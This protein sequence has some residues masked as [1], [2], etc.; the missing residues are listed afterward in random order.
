MPNAVK[1]CPAVR[2]ALAKEISQW[3]ARLAFGLFPTQLCL[4]QCLAYINAIGVH[5]TRSSLIIRKTHAQNAV[6]VCQGASTAMVTHP[7][8]YDARISTS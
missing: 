1:R 4:I 6:H 5:R 7:D 3:T 2:I 8:V